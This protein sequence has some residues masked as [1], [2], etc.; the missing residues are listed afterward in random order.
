MDAYGISTDKKKGR[1][2]PRNG[3]KTKTNEEELEGLVASIAKSRR[4]NRARH[5]FE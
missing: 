3:R 2:Q 5:D 1:L 4:Q